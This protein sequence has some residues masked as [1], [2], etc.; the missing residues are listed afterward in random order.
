MMSGGVVWV[1][2]AQVLRA[3]FTRRARSTLLSPDPIVTRRVPLG[4]LC[5][6]LPL[7]CLRPSFLLRVIKTKLM[8]AL[9]EGFNTFRNFVAGNRD[10]K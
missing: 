9:V 8:A 5:E 7:R 3:M 10:H 2:Q 1:V 6:R 4:A